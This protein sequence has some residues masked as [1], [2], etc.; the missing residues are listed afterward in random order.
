MSERPPSGAAGLGILATLLLIVASAL[1]WNVIYLGPRPVS[2]RLPGRD[3]LLV[4][5]SAG[6][7]R[8]ASRPSSASR[9]PAPRPR[10]PGDRRPTPR[11]TAPETRRYQ[12]KD[13]QCLYEIADEVYGDGNR[14]REIARENGLVDP[15][16]LRKGQMLRIP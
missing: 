13:G 14:W 6:P 10:P 3:R 5:E 2:D 1:V 12:V 15:Y 7:L 11:P 4:V 16:V 8:S 9:A